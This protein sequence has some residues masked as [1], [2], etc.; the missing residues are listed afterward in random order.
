MPSDTPRDPA[1]LYDLGLATAKR[2]D[3]P[4]AER[5][6][7][8]A[9]VR[10]EQAMLT[11]PT[12]AAATLLAK[13]LVAVDRRAAAAT[14]FARHSAAPYDVIMCFAQIFTQLGERERAIAAYDAAAAG[15]QFT[16]AE[17]TGPVAAWALNSPF[18]AKSPSPRYAALLAQYALMHQAGKADS[19]SQGAKT[20]EGFVGFSIVAPYVRRFGK[21][22]GA[23]SLLDYGGGRGMQYRLGPIT[24]AEETFADP[25]AYLG[26]E[27]VVCFDPGLDRELPSGKFDLVICV[28]ALE[29][30]DRQDLPWIVRQLFEKA[31]LGVFANIASYPAAK[32]LPNGEN[33]HCTVEDTAWWMGLF[34]AVA[35]DF[36]HVAYQVIVSKDLR[37][38][39]RSIF[40]RD[41]SA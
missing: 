12:S 34:R 24:T 39:T 23:T 15:R 2:G 7:N 37:Q 30:C 33:A 6:L 20:F 17:N 4:E 41:P 21:M 29:H 35:A 25:L 10:A 22:I 32:A 18:T 13:C 28:D 9:V 14:M 11:N 38:N 5:L 3:M 16:V 31:R 40:G 19:Q 1:S 36:P 26:I 27:Q 8:E